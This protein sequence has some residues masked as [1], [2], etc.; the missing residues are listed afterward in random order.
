MLARAQDPWSFVAPLNAPQA[1]PPG[2]THARSASA[3]PTSRWV[4]TIEEAAWL[5]QSHPQ[6]AFLLGARQ[7]EGDSCGA[8][9]GCLLV[10]NWTRLELQSRGSIG[11]EVAFIRELAP[12]ASGVMAAL[13]D[14]Y[15]N[16]QSGAIPDDEGQDS[17]EFVVRCALD[18]VDR[19]ALLREEV[20]R[21][22]ASLAG[23]FSTMLVR[24]EWGLSVDDV[25]YGMQ[26]SVPLCW[27]IDP[28][29][30]EGYLDDSIA[31]PAGNVKSL[32][33]AQLGVRDS[34][35]LT[36]VHTALGL[37]GMNVWLWGRSVDQRA[38]LVE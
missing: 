29:E 9:Q 32:L 16:W 17:D 37:E 3:T 18:D 13:R 10:F 24:H 1:R 26:R 11:R 20:Q 36:H 31:G 22:S 38:M 4:P 33:E 12:F 2:T 19:G 30:S 8:P 7:G 15:E 6:T 21:A 5:A 27:L 35:P 34:E 28:D 14:A 25:V 23:K